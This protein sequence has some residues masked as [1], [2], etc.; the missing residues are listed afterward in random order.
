MRE[1]GVFRSQ[2]REHAAL[3]EPCGIVISS[4]LFTLLHIAYWRKPLM[5]AY[6]FACGLVFGGPSGRCKPRRRLRTSRR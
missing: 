2:L 5:L 3:L 4:L 1:Q 6:V